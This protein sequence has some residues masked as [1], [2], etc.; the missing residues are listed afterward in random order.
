M[1]VAALALTISNF[2]LL[3]PSWA[4]TAGAAVWYT[5]PV[6]ILA[7]LVSFGRR[8]PLPRGSTL[9]IPAALTL[10]LLLTSGPRTTRYLTGDLRSASWAYSNDARSV[11]AHQ[12][13]PF[14]VVPNALAVRVLLVAWAVW[15]V[16]A[17]IVVVRRRAGGSPAKLVAAAAS[18]ATTLFLAWP[19]RL[20]PE[21]ARRSSSAGTWTSS[22]LSRWR[23]RPSWPAPRIWSELVEPRL[24]RSVG[25]ALQ[26]DTD[27]SPAAQRRRLVRTLGDPTV[28]IA[29]RTDDGGWIDEAGRVT[30]L[31]TDP[32]RAVTVVRRGGRTLAA[33]EHD[34]SLRGQP[35]LLEVAATSLAMT[36][37]A[38]RQAV[39]ANAAAEDARASAA[40][41]L[42][43]ADGGRQGVE[44]EIAAGPDAT[45]AATAAL[46]SARPLP[47]ADVHDGLRTALT[48]VRAIAHGS[49][50]PSLQDHGLT[51][52]LD[53]LR[54]TAPVALTVRQ[55]S[56]RRLPPVVES[57]VF[58][59]VRDAVETATGPVEAALAAT[60]DEVRV[61]ISGPSVTVHRLTVDRVEA[62]DG[63]AEQAAGVVRLT[64][65]ARAV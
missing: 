64:L 27:A 7:T 52:A 48:Q 49:T 25:G 26:L 58:G 20:L 56:D 5:T 6:L 28:R 30:D 37:D 46:L 17:A 53:D 50:P 42:V 41:L 47:L 13:N 39:V 38:Q 24:S 54:A 33:L 22:W 10:G 14:A 43:A 21:E 62:L 29:F 23:R 51:V 15:L 2:R 61:L 65:P 35:D 44:E 57:T 18:V 9:A 34:A 3:E 55:G 40:R 11:A 60:D 63:H 12:G 1:V 59:A 19:E 32:P 8:T 31:D 36:L 16:W 4:A 45:L